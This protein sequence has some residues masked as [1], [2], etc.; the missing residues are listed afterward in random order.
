LAQLAPGPIPEEFL[1]A[2]PAEQKTPAVR[3][4][5]RSRH[6]VTGGGGPSFGV[7]HRLMADF[8]RGMAGERE[9]DLLTAACH[10]LAQVMTPER[11]RDPHHWP[12]MNLCRLHAELLF[13]R[14]VS[15]VESAI[16]ASE[17][18]LTTAILASAQGDHAGARQLQEQVLEV[19]TRVLGEEHPATLT[20]MNNLAVT[21]NG[22]GELDAAL[23]LLRKSLGGH[24]QVLGDNHPDTIAISKFLTRLEEPPATSGREHQS[25]I[26]RA[27]RALAALFGKN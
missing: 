2:L 1:E 5:L 17:I 27:S 6:F 7:M 3:V 26:Q 24:R 15:Q 10:A 16:E 20:S 9:S 13:A 21:L 4:A 11:C 18:G 14:G 23:P 12:S 22:L 8:L 25:W 19:M